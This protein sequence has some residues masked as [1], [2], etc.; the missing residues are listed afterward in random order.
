MRNNDAHSLSWTEFLLIQQAE[1]QV[2][3]Q[4][5]GLTPQ[6]YYTR[7]FLSFS[8]YRASIVIFCIVISSIILASFPSAYATKYLLQM[9]NR[10]AW[11]VVYVQPAYFTK[12]HTSY[13]F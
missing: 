8:S 1:R 9:D 7:P 4:R 5:I 3:H 13:F 2:E 6:E 11:D 12:V 10:S